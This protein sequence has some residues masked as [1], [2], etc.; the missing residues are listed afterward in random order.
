MDGQDDKNIRQYDYK[1]NMKKIKVPIEVS[2]RHLHLSVADV[3][4]LFGNNYKLHKKNDISQTGQFATKEILSV[5]GPQEKF[6]K[7]R[8]VGPERQQSQLELSITDCY[9]LGVRPQINVSGDIKGAPQVTVRGPK[10][11]IKVPAIVAKRHL[12]LSNQDSKK[13]KLSPGRRVQVKINSQRSI[14]FDQVIVRIHPTFR[15][16]MHIDTDE[17]NAAGVKAGDMGEMLI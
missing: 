2:A 1:N 13:Y 14:I 8:I 16:R 10:G 17:A 15:F 7:V 5:I 9:R 12:H 6:E 11:R 3:N 4:K